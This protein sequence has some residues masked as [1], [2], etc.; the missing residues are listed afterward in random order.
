[1]SF[2]NSQQAACPWLDQAHGARAVCFKCQACW[3]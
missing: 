3:L 2:Q 1:M